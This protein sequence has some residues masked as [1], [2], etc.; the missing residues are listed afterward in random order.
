MA[1]ISVN[2]DEGILRKLKKAAV[3]EGRSVSEIIRA[4]IVEFLRDRGMIR[5][6]EDHDGCGVD[7]EKG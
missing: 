6:S 2:V 4:L 5:Y 3:Q 7:S 1:R